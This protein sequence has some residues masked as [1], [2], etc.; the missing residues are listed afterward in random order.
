MT[1]FPVVM[2]VI[3]VGHEPS[4]KEKVAHLSRSAREALK[5]S[6][7]KS[8][9]RLGELFKDE[10]GVPCPVAGNYWSLSH[11]PKYVAA[12]VSKNKVGIDIE[13]MKPRTES[14]FAHMASDEEWGLKEKSWDTFFRYWTAKEAALKVIGIGISGLKTCRI[15]SVPDENHIVLDYKGQSFLVEQLLCKNHIVSVLK[16]DNQIEW[17]VLDE[18]PDNMT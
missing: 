5:L 9:L 11:K 7:E 3:E 2:P 8:R 1:L 18:F 17:V 13:E 12:V 10:K 16:D 15:I 6:A 14:L 4:G